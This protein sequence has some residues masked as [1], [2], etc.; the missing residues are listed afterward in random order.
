MYSDLSPSLASI[1][2]LLVLPFSSNPAAAQCTVERIGYEGAVGGGLD[3][4]RAWL[5]ATVGDCTPSKISNWKNE[6]RAILRDAAGTSELGRKKEQEAHTAALDAMVKSAQCFRDAAT[7]LRDLFTHCNPESPTVNLAK[8]LENALG[9]P[10]VVE[11]C[12]DAGRKVDKAR[13]LYR[14][15]KDHY[16]AAEVAFSDQGGD[17]IAVRPAA[18]NETTCAET[19]AAIRT[20]ATAAKQRS[21]RNRRILTDTKQKVDDLIGHLERCAENPKECTPIEQPSTPGLEDPDSAPDLVLP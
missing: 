15:A 17:D 9:I 14:Q 18:C 12:Q 8:C 4:L 21:A 20:S 2:L 5:D 10:D 7:T 1:L 16:G 6:C 13:D 3:S 19:A 11:T